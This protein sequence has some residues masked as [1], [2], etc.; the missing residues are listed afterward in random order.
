MKTEDPDLSWW[1][2]RV[3]WNKQGLCS[4]KACDQEHDDWVHPNTGLRYCN[5]CKRAL[6]T[7]NA[8]LGLKLNKK[9]IEE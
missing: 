1:A 7:V 4:M 6:E 8:D 3:I 9:E 5:R 2:N